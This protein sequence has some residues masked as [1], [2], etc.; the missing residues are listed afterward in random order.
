MIRKARQEDIK[1][2][3]KIYEA[4][5]DQQDAGKASIGWIKGV[6]PT[7]STAQ[8]AL[9]KGELFVYDEDGFITAAAKINQKQE[10]AYK[11]ANW[12]YNV[13]DCEVMVLHTLVVLPGQ[14]GKGIGS[15]FV[16]F[17]EDYAL[18]QGCR[19]LRMD[20][21]EINRTARS[22][23]RKL[24]YKEVGIVPCEFNGIENVNLVCLEKKL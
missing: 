24:G 8:E 1:K 11:E 5:L 4:I 14:A 2:V 10:P 16:A 6:Y 3:A 22:L 15:K 21:N 19:Y 18:Q 7:E 13:Q 9:E 23:Y 12:E 17:Y 20:T